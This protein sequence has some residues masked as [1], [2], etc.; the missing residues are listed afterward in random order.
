MISSRPVRKKKKSKLFSWNQQ[1]LQTSHHQLTILDLADTKTGTQ[2][3]L[4]TCWFWG[5]MK[6]SVPPFGGSSATSLQNR[7]RGWI[8]TS[9]GC[10]IVTPAHTHIR[11]PSDTVSTEDTLWLTELTRLLFPC[12][13][14]IKIQLIILS[15]RIYSLSEGFIIRSGTNTNKS[16]PPLRHQTR[17]EWWSNPMGTEIKA[18]QRNA[19][20]KTGSSDDK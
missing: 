17:A 6:E 3:C 20:A 7:I 15:M 16:P 8:S 11:W 12:A 9:L 1:I 5:G 2:A 13:G 4:C 14:S 10:Y 18:E 19:F